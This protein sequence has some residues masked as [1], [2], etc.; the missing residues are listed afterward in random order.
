MLQYRAQAA[1]ICGRI[2]T[3][4]GCIAETARR[5]VPT[6]RSR[7]IF[8][9]THPQCLSRLGAYR[10]QVEYWGFQQSCSIYKHAALNWETEARK[11]GR[12]WLERRDTLWSLR[13]R[14]DAEGIAHFWRDLLAAVAAEQDL[15][16]CACCH[17]PMQ[18]S[19]RGPPQSPG[20]LS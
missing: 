5:S 16:T 10:G 9:K 12:V 20:R 19:S 2:R 13:S 3:S 1:T 14:A 11:E 17:A 4:P 7:K 15:A 6:N 8:L 18:T